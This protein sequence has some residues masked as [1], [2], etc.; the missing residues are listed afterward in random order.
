[1]NNRFIIVLPIS[2]FFFSC[3]GT[4]LT[5]IS[6]Y[7]NTDIQVLDRPDTIYGRNEPKI[8]YKNDLFSITSPGNLLLP[9]YG[10]DRIYSN[11]VENG[12]HDRSLLVKVIVNNIE[13]II[14]PE[15]MAYILSNI[16]LYDK[17]T[18]RYYITIT[19]LLNVL[20]LEMQDIDNIVLITYNPR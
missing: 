13:C 4:P 8:I 12:Y 10:E 19:E 20:N 17:D 9:E 3:T 15:I 5:Y 11:L 6:F 16:A 7:N 14:T 18:R 2:L 1:M